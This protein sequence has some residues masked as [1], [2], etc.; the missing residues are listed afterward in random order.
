MSR[1]QAFVIATE[2]QR[3]DAAFQLLGM[4][5]NSLSTAAHILI[6][7]DEDLN[8]L[9]S[10]DAYLAGHKEGMAQA[11]KS[12]LVEDDPNEHDGRGPG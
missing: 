2:L 8:R 12:G 3:I 1:S 5:N 6:R 4:R 11:F 10:S 7:Q 9:R